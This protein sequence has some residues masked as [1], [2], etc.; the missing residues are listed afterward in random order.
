METITGLSMVIWCAW[1]LVG[2][3]IRD[4]P[5]GGRGLI[6][7]ESGFRIIDISKMQVVSFS[8]ALIRNIFTLIEVSL[9][10]SII[11]YLFGNEV[12]WISSVLTVICII[13]LEYFC[14]YLSNGKDR[15]I[16][17]VLGLKVVSE[18]SIIVKGKRITLK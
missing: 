5:R 10:G 16:D 1:I 2:G 4:L 15:W 17:S 14:S 8:K 9:I 6:R 11:Y 7:G 13:L 3:L 18:D 12:T